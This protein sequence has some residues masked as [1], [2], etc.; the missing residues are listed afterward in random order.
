MNAISTIILIFSM[1]GAMDKLLGDRFGL[2]KEFERAFSLFTPMALSMLGMLVLAP[3]IGVW[4][5]PVFEGFYHI[6]G[7]DPSILPASLFA[8]DMGGMT[9]ARQICRSQDVGNY[10]AYVVSSMMGCVISFTI[11][12]ATGIVKS[13]QHRELFLGLLCGIVTIPVGCFAAGILCELP[14][15]VLL[16]VLMPL[17]ILS[18]IL[19]AGLLLLPEAC[20]KV[21]SVFGKVI[22]IVSILGLVCAIYTFLTD[23]SLNEHFDTLENAAWVCVNACVTFSGALPFMYV[24]SKLLSKPVDRWGKRLGI[25][26]LSAVAFLSTLVTNASTFGMMEKMNKKGVVVNSAFAVSASFVFGSHLAF[27]MAFDEGYVFPMIVGKLSSG[28]CAMILAF[29]IYNRAD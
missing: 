13:D 5:T 29:A 19:A 17:L 25:D 2:G 14:F 1:F 7:I 10:N 11:P 20:I 23:R 9:L 22:R 26:S 6:F 28:L 21:F 4:L 16:T 3:A 12:F 18:A 8:N 15:M 24:V 27:T